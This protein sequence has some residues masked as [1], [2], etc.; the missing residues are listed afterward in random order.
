MTPAQADLLRDLIAADRRYRSLVSSGLPA[1]PDDRG[2]EVCSLTGVDPRT[3]RSLE[4][5]GLVEVLDTG[6]TGSKWVFLGRYAPYE[7]PT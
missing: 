2:V 7:D 4:E 5:A 1:H 3:A 6:R